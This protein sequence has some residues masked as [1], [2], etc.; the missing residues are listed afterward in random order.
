M[1]PSEA[2]R[3]GVKPQLC[4]LVAR[5]LGT[6][7]LPPQGLSFLI[8]K[9]VGG[10]NNGTT[11]VGCHVDFMRESMQVTCPG[12]GPWRAHDPWEFGLSLPA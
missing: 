7:I 6:V 4:H 5:D 8:C 11:W 12:L 3:L 2:Q 9:M 10:G 1:R